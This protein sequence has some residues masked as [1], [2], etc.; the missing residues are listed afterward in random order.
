MVTSIFEINKQST[1]E[2]SGIKK[3]HHLLLIKENLLNICNN[4]YSYIDSYFKVNI[5]LNSLEVIESHIVWYKA[6]NSKKY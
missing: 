2:F 4:W 1:T 5:Y 6:S 3:T